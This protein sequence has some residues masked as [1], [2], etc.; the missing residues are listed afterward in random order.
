M[1]QVHDLLSL[2][3]IPGNH[4]EQCVISGPDHT[5]QKQHNISKIILNALHKQALWGYDFYA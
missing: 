4:S 5:F 2:S 1:E 3:I